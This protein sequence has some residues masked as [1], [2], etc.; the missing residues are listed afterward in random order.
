MYVSKQYVYT[1]DQGESISFYWRGGP[2]PCVSALIYHVVFVS[3]LY[4]IPS[5]SLM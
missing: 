2:R 1:V 3:W 4:C 5:G